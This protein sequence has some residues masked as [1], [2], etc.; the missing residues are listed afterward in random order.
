[1]ILVFRAAAYRRAG[2]WY[3]ENT[4]N[5][6]FNDPTGLLR[7]IR[8][9]KYRRRRH[10]NCLQKNFNKKYLE[11]TAYCVLQVLP[12]IHARS[13]QQAFNAI[14]LFQL[15]CLPHA[16]SKNKSMTT[17]CVSVNAA[18]RTKK[19]E[20]SKRNMFLLSTASISK[21]N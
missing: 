4:R 14:S 15:S 2:N 1:M 18:G 21:C 5:T 17:G 20:K 7:S 12:T 10:N 9:T 13:L 3:S 8:N 6:R 19:F 16:A 11:F